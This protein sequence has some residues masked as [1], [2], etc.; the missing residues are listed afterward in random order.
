MGILEAIKKA[1]DMM[2]G[3]ASSVG[4][5]VLVIIIIGLVAGVFVYETVTAGNIN[6]DNTSSSLIA[7]QTAEFASVTVVLWNAVTSVTGFIV[8][9]VIALIAIAILGPKFL[10]GN[11]L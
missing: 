4:A 11:K 10:R 7:N 1:F 8:L 5:L 2:P 9:G 3:L 6:V